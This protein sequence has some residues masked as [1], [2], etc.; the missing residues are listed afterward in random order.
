VFADPTRF[1]P[2]IPHGRITV[3]PLPL[4]L[5]PAS[6]VQITVEPSFR[7]AL[8]VCGETE[9]VA[10]ADN[11]TQSA[12]CF[13]PA[14]AGI[15]ALAAVPAAGSLT[16]DQREPFSTIPPP[17]KLRPVNVTAVGKLLAETSVPPTPS[18]VATT[19]PPPA[20]TVTFIRMKFAM[21][22]DEEADIPGVVQF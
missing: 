8:I 3:E 14:S 22:V 13:T 1:N 2:H 16:T 10:S 7:L 4:E 20:S 5:T 11:V 21:I 18:Y 9:P 6:T 19:E 17:A 12:T 15:T